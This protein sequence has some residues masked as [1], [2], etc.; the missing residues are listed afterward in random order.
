[1]FYLQTVTSAKCLEEFSKAYSKSSEIA[2]EPLSTKSTSFQVDSSLP[3]LLHVIRRMSGS[4][5]G[6]NGIAGLV[7]KHCIGSLARPLLTIFQQSVFQKRI[8]RAWKVAKVFP[9]YKV[10][11]DKGSAFSYR[12]TSLT[13]VACKILRGT[14]I[15]QWFNFLSRQERLTGFESAG[16]PSCEVHR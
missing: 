7:Y 1:M 3:A 2:V 10:K 14:L 13:S 12:P 15:R 9:L 16:L 11:G 4:A 5:A 6:P 8:P